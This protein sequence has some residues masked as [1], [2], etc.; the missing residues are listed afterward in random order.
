MHLDV[1]YFVDDIKLSDVCGLQ[2]GGRGGFRHGRAHGQP[3]PGENNFKYANCNDNF[4]CLILA[5]Q[6]QVCKK[7]WK[8]SG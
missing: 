4:D 6:G 3:G 1:Q 5:S 2:P 8:H 7:V